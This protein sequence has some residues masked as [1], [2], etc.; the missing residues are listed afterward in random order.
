MSATNDLCDTRPRP[1]GELILQTLA[2]PKDGNPNG[3]IF[4]GWLMS[5]M[6]L[7][8][9][10][11]A[12]MQARGRIATVAVDAMVFLKPVK[13]GDIVSF[14][15]HVQSIGRSSMKIQVDVWKT[16]DLTGEQTKLTEGLF[17]FV[18]IDDNGNTRA[19]PRD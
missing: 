6:D 12:R 14:H 3:D 5:Q 10:V 19:V 18:A 8:G 11:T 13:V 9:G 1:Q 15:T 17:S 4:G 16:C 2:M 7:A